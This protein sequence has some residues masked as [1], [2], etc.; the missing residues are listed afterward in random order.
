MA[1]ASAARE[2]KRQQDKA[3]YQR[4]R[5][6]RI[7][8]C[9]PCPVAKLTEIECAYIAGLIDGEGSLFIAKHAGGLHPAISISMTSRDVLA[10]LGDLLGAALCQVERKNDG[11]RDQFSVRIHGQKAVN[12][13]TRMV[14]YLRV[15]REQAILFAQFPG[16]QRIAPGCRIASA[17]LIKRAE[18]RERINGLNARGKVNTHA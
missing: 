10:W 15:K 6:K 13:A 18:L 11:W 2:V 12:L 3:R 7:A 14:P 9:E 17:V 8:M 5:A 4:I 16:D 1:D